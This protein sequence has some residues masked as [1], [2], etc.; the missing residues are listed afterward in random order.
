MLSDFL[1]VYQL[2]R[3]GSGQSYALLVLVAAYDVNDV[4]N[5]SQ[6]ASW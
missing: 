6:P 5:V 1:R 4:F 3:T 2:C